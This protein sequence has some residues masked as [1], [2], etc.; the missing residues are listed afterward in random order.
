MVVLTVTGTILRNKV[1][2][3]TF[4][5][6]A[7]CSLSQSIIAGYIPS[8]TLETR[9]SLIRSIIN[10]SRETINQ[11]LSKTKGAVK[12]VLNIRDDISTMIQR[13]VVPEE[14]LS[15]KSFDELLQEWLAPVFCVDALQ[16]QRVTF[17][18]S[19]GLILEK[20]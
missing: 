13:A 6:T 3:R 11:D 15:L 14:K 19:S 1:S 12:V 7:K 5:R 8:D 4:I 10:S 9:T 17:D 18:H 2:A 20:V 16:L